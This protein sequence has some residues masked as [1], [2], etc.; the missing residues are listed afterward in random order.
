MAMPLNI[1]NDEVERLVSEIAA[2]T[3]ETKTEAVRRALLE[4]RDRLAF[5]AEKT[6][7]GDRL[8]RVLEQEVWPLVP[9]KERGRRL[10]RRQKDAILGYGPEGT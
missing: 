9:R 3:G 8:L 4:R 10:T 2:L 7:P 5:R 6:R 1:K